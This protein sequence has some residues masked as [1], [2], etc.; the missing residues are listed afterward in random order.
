VRLEEIA[1]TEELS[2]FQGFNPEPC[3]P[4][5]SGKEKKLW[6]SCIRLYASE[7][8]D[9]SMAIQFN[10]QIVRSGTIG[11]DYS[12]IWCPVDFRKPSS[13]RDNR[14]GR[15]LRCSLDST[16]KARIKSTASFY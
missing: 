14:I 12:E 10:L 1:E 9:S 13:V 11:W 7:R 16:Q 5:A 4:F 15:P 6:T 2:Q 3:V 8:T